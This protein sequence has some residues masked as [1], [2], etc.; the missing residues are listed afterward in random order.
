MGR[1]HRHF[2]AKKKKKKHTSYSKIDIIDDPIQIPDGTG[3]IITLT[4]ATFTA[5]EGGKIV[6]AINR[7]GGLLGNVTVNYV[8]SDLTAIAGT[9]YVAASGS[10]TFLSNA[11]ST[12]Y[13]AIKTTRRLDTE[14]ES[15]FKFT[16]SIDYTIPNLAIL[17]QYSEATITILRHGYG[18]FQFPGLQYEKQD[19]NSGTTTLIVPINRSGS[20]DASTIQ[21]ATS[22]GTAIAGTDYVAASG[23]LSFIDN[24]M[25]KSID[26]TINGRSGNQGSRSF[27]LT[28]SNPTGPTTLNEDSNVATITIV[29][30]SAT[31]N[32]NGNPQYYIYDTMIYISSDIIYE[33]TT[34]V[35]DNITWNSG[36]CQKIGDK[37]GICKATP[38]SSTD[39]KNTDP[40]FKQTPP[41]R[42]NILIT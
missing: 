21:Y 7:T 32:P 1:R 25:S 37:I 10:V 16:I 6:L 12:K 13:V 33:D 41:N 2:W 40:T 9:D 39:F 29:E 27:S 11:Q 24:E 4:S 35:G 38:Y 42:F 14:E 15:D 5:L 17:G 31:S 36:F 28:L 22:N 20:K 26:I 18:E 34:T 30:G 8:T 19:P 23:T 3:G